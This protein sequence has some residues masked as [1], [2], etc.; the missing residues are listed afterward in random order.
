MNRQRVYIGVYKKNNQ[1]SLFYQEDIGLFYDL[2]QKKMIFSYE[3]EENLIPYSNIIKEE[4]RFKKDII[5]LYDLDR[6]K[7]ISLNRVLIGKVFELEDVHIIND[8]N[9]SLEKLD[10]SYKGTASNKLIKEDALLLSNEL[11]CDGIEDVVDLMDIETGI[12]YNE[13]ID[14]KNGTQYVPRTKNT[15]CYAKDVMKID[16][17]TMEKGKLLEKYREYKRR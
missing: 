3:L 4:R 14:L 5:K 15:L 6:M 1:E 16:V 9:F 12:W 11:F 10:I 2:K 13:N 8:F 17:E 7:K